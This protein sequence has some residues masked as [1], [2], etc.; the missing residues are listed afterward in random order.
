MIKDKSHKH[1]PFQIFQY[2]GYF[3]G[4]LLPVGVFIIFELSGLEQNILRGINE[5]PFIILTL[6]G[7]LIA[8]LTFFIENHY[9]KKSKLFGSLFLVQALFSFFLIHLLVLYSNGHAFY[10]ETIGRHEGMHK[11]QLS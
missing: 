2:I 11:T 3:L 6:V 1:T 7:F 9:T 8:F 4:G 10:V 5:S